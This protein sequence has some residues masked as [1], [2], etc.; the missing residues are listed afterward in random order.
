MFVSATNV[1][2]P[3]HSANT[4]GIALV[5]AEDGL[6]P[7][8]IARRINVPRTTVRDWLNGHLPKTVAL[9]GDH[10]GACDRCGH[11]A[12]SY[13][14]LTAAYV[15]LLGLYLGDGCISIPQARRL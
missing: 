13:G 7:C 3:V 14:K 12:H 2:T 6:N 1:A 4:I 9:D 10:R 5:L 15:Y 11:P 8:E